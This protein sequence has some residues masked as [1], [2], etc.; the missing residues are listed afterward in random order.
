MPYVHEGII[1]RK[2]REQR[3]ITQEKLALGIIDRSNL[4]RVEAGKQRLSK[5]KLD[6]MVNRLGY[7]ASRFFNFALST[8]ECEAYALR[9]RIDASLTRYDAQESKELLHIMESH[10]AFNKGYHKQFLLKSKAAY[11]ILFD[12]DKETARVLLDEAIRISIPKYEDRFVNKYL[13]TKEEVLIID[14]M[15]LIYSMDAKYDAAIELLRKLEKNINKNYVDEIEKAHS[16]SLVYYNLSKYLGICRQYREAVAVCDEAIEMGQ[17]RRVYGY[18]PLLMY[19]K[20]YCLYHLDESD[21]MLSLLQQAYFAC[22]CMG[23]D[24]AAN[25]IKERAEDN[26]KIKLE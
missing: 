8:N 10:S 24:E 23:L 1:I 16:I 14:S 18:L 6:A 20:A 17:R 25:M 12:N 5:S 4:A 11:N 3:G 2:L 13:L 21:K 26:Y 9:D 19:N 22:L 15:A 7:S